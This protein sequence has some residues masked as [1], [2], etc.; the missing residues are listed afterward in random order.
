MVFG[1]LVLVLYLNS[2]K[3]K[4]PLWNP[5]SGS[6]SGVLGCSRCGAS[7][8]L[9]CWLSYG[10]HG[11]WLYTETH[12]GD[13]CAVLCCLCFWE[14]LN[15]KEKKCFKNI[16]NH[17]SL[18]FSDYLSLFSECWK[19]S[20]K[21]EFSLSPALN[22][23]K[24]SLHSCLLMSLKGSYFCKV[25]TISLLSEWVAMQRTA[26]SIPARRGCLEYSSEMF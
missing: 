16:L 3:I 17:C 4:T 24:Q 13:S 9:C 14:E 11:K 2:P 8:V 23:N 12:K 19:H 18:L 1:Y 26:E 7:S 21:V 25:N 5:S 15:S 22:A 20:Q 6:I 10:S